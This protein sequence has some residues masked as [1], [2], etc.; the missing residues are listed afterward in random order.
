MNPVAISRV[1]RFAL[2]ILAFTLIVIA[3]HGCTS[4]NPTGENGAA[5]LNFNS[6]DDALQSLITA[7]RAHD[8]KKLEAIFGPDSDDLLFSGDPVDD[9][10]TF[11]RFVTAYDQKHTLVSNDDGSMSIIVGNDDWPMPIP[12]IKDQ[13]GKG[14]VFDTPDGKDEVI[15]RRIGRNELTV[16][17]VCQA[18][19]DAE[20]EYAQRDAKNDE[21]P[22]YA[23]SSSA[24]QVRPTAFTGLPLR[25]NR[26]ARWALPLPRRKARDTPPIRIRPTNPGPI[27]ATCIEF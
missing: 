11:D 4:T 27:M 20:R 12:L 24:I 26:P 5:Q 18:I 22:E 1:S 25:T 21:M 3:S 14:W 7:M 15:A 16:I 6:P 8:T 23:A 17:E 10:L 13:S 9:Q 2:G 19:C